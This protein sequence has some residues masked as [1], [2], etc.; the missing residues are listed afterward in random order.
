VITTKGVAG[1][2]KGKYLIAKKRYSLPSCLGYNQH[3]QTNNFTSLPQ[4]QQ[5]HYQAPLR[6]RVHILHPP[7]CLP[8]SRDNGVASKVFKHFTPFLKYI[9]YFPEDQQR[10]FLCKKQWGMLLVHSWFF[11]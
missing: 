2:D 3:Q 11:Q 10:Q 7:L 5:G 9:E 8:P 4:E 1:E 6:H